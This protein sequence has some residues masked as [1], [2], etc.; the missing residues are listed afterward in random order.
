MEFLD[1]PGHIDAFPAHS[2]RTIIQLCD[3]THKH[4]IV[5]FAGHSK[6]KS[7]TNSFV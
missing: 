1:S 2:A 6:S 3:V 5:F 4:W 7:S